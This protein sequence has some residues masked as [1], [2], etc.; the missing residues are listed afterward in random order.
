MVLLSKTLHF[1]RL[2]FPC[3]SAEH[4]AFGGALRCSRGSLLE[5]SCVCKDG[6]KVTT[7][8]P[9]HFCYYHHYCIV[10]SILPPPPKRWDPRSA[11]TH[12]ALLLS[13]LYVDAFKTTQKAPKL[14]IALEPVD[15]VISSPPS[16]VLP[17]SGKSGSNTDQNSC[18][19]TLTLSVL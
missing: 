4:L 3:L 12:A 6:A 1:C 14:N 5:Q 18:M 19:Q 2:Q 7:L 16:G 15:E 13:C 9:W 8:Q 10:L 11:L 17:C